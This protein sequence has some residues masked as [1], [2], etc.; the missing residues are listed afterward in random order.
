MVDL[1]VYT[2]HRIGDMYYNTPV[3]HCENIRYGRVELTAPL[4]STMVTD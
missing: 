2:N 4:V 3:P 1:S